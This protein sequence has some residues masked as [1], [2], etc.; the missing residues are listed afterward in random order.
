M[1]DSNWKQHIELTQTIRRHPD[2][3]DDQV[4]EFLRLHPLERD[5]VTVARREV[6]TEDT[7]GVTSSERSY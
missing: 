6:E 5:K 3:D 7:P 1:A 2:W 4:M